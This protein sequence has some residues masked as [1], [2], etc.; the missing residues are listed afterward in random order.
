M[1][2][3]TS[4]FILLSTILYLFLAIIWKHSD[5]TN[6]VLKVVFYLLAFYGFYLVLVA[7]IKQGYAF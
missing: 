6:A 5:W 4:T 2:D 7:L 3:Q 1:L